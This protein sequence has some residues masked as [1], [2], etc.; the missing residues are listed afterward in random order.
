MSFLFQFNQDLYSSS[1]VPLAS[2]STS[3]GS[4]SPCSPL[5]P[6]TSSLASNPIQS[7]SSNLS[8]APSLG[9]NHTRPITKEEDLSATRSD[10]EGK[11]SLLI[12][13]TTRHIN[14]TPPVADFVFS[15]GNRHHLIAG[16]LSG[17]HNESSCS[18]DPES[19]HGEHSSEASRAQYL[20]ATCVVFTNYSGDVAAVVDEH[21]TR[22]L[23]FSE[24][25]SKGDLTIVNFMFVLFCEIQFTVPIKCLLNSQ[26]CQSAECKNRRNEKSLNEKESYSITLLLLIKA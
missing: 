15:K 1:G 16:A 17:A 24:K 23:N 13:S 20:S 22:A 9:G 8:V 12:S 3:A 10:T 25:D 19:N 5:L 7:T 6:S 14:L 11:F 26:Q 18:S 2:S 21:F 4:H